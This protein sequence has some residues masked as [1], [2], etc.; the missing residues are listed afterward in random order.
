MFDRVA[1]RAWGISGRL[2]A[3]YVLVT[4]A[5]VVLVE[6]L[7]LG[8]QAP[9]LVDDVQLQTQVGAT[10]KTYTRHLMQ[11]YP[12][13]APPVGALL[14]ERGQLARP[15]EARLSSDGSTLV[16]PAITGPLHSRKA[17]TAVIAI[18]ADNRVTASS[19]PS[20]YP[21][22]RPMRGEVPAAAAE[23]LARGHFVGSVTS[24]TTYGGRVIWAISVL[25]GAGDKP[26]GG[27][28]SRAAYL[29]LQAP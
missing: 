20:R 9:R 25:P 8:Y 12:G 5:V 28:P 14:G 24:G 1:R 4:L 18:A 15:G 19:A 29:Y 17:V 26:L 16:V 3:T 22:G 23:S 7:V 21:P 13:G 27:S 10:L 2:T 11:I 6:A